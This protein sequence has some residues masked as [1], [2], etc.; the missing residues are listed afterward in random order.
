M[1]DALHVE[2][3]KTW[4]TLDIT[5]STLTCLFGTN[6][7][8]KSS[9]IQ[10]LLLLKQTK[11]AT[12]RG[13]AFD[14]NG[15]YT[16]LGDY[17]DVVHGHDNES[18]ISWRLTI[19][20]DERLSLQ[21]PST[22]RQTAL[23]RAKSFEVAGQ[24]RWGATGAQ[25]T[26]LNYR[27][28][29]QQFSLAPKREESAFDLKA[30][31]GTFKFVRTPGR[32]WQLP[33]PIKSYAFPDQA[34]TYFQ[35]A[36]F[37]ADLE[38]AFERQIDQ[39]FYLGP[40][41]E[42]PK[43]DYTWARTRPVDVGVRGEK[44]IDAIL[45]ATATKERHNLYHK[46][47]LKSFQEII[48]H[49]LKQMGLIHNFSVKEIAPGSNYYQAVVQSREGGPDVAL[50]DV[51]FGVSQVLPVIVLLYYVPEGSTIILEQPEIHLHP[52]A[53]AELADLIYT[54]AWRR[55]LQIIIETHSEHLLLR[56]QRRV[57]EEE[58]EEGD[59]SI[60]YSEAKGSQS[61]LRNLEV[62]ALGQVSQWPE[63]FMGDA[64][65]ETMA[66]ERARLERL[67]A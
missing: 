61:K 18:R 5:F 9:V 1:L 43:R 64:F 22:S 49:W 14:F 41:R 47:R 3:F 35:N 4:K 23:V 66:A 44:V 50:T 42:F 56:L 8:G 67:K 17:T 38:T 60:Y 25:A 20:R 48:A 15:N 13:I 33:G 52:L 24:V 57:A 59:L 10:F 53:Q 30:S 2:N 40:L 26:L 7:S 27:I 63:N 45:A 58:I 46:G 65:G 28:G 29:N 39:I 6:S 16:K 36:S 54:V 34:R 32:A 31:G 37:L 55:S 51:G 21:D 19:S 62:N 12:D 11:E